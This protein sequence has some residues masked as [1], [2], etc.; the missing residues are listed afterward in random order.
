MRPL[1][2]VLSAGI[3]LSPLAA[4]AAPAASAAVAGDARCLMT[5]AAL[6]SSSDQTRARTAQVG[7]IYFAGRIKAQDPSYDFG[8]Q[9]KTVATSLNR[10]TLN[11]EA[12][13]C[14]PLLV[15]TLRQLDA[16][17]KSS[18]QAKP[19]PTGAAP[20]AKPAPKPAP[21]P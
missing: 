11:A 1:T 18:P 5:M 9:L 21:K 12:Q 16:A 6:S 14:G 8:S 7:V 19:A 2:L 4:A 15:E 20:A 10:D 17:Q 13:R 3:A